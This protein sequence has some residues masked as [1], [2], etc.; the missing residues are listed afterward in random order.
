MFTSQ[1]SSF[2]TFR[3]TADLL[4]DS[5]TDKIGSDLEWAKQDVNSSEVLR[6]Y[7]RLPPIIN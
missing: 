6:V 7:G 2:L 3:P 5:S 4:F 1:S